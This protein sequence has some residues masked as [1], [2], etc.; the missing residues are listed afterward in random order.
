MAGRYGRPVPGEPTDPRHPV[1]ENFR[2]TLDLPVRKLPVMG[3]GL[4]QDFFEYDKYPNLKQCAS[5]ITEVYDGEFSRP[6]TLRGCGYEQEPR[7]TLPLF[8]ISLHQIWTRPSRTSSR[9]ASTESRRAS[10]SSESPSPRCLT[11]SPTAREP[12]R[13]WRTS[14]ASSRRGLCAADQV[15]NLGYHPLRTRLLSAPRTRPYWP[16]TRR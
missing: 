5:D 2:S 13:M 11:P 16:V 1:R 12:W 9:R 7:L 10:S 14:L 15:S 8:S 6:E 3:E 4:V